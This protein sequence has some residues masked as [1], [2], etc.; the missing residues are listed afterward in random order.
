MSELLAYRPPTIN[1]ELLPSE[2]QLIAWRLTNALASLAGYQQDLEA[3]LALFDFCNH[4]MTG[5]ET[6]EPSIGLFRSWRSLAGRDGAMSIYH[7]GMT[8]ERVR[9]VIFRDCPCLASHFDRS[10][11]RSVIGSFDQA[12]PNWKSLRNAVAHVAENFVDPDEPTK[13]FVPSG[14]DSRVKIARRNVLDG[15]KFMHTIAGK[16][17]SYEL[18][19]EIV[20]KL[21]NIRGRYYRIFSKVSP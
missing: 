10:E 18:S 8:L 16:E 4:Q 5:L 21:H 12:F 19:A 7:F 17:C 1:M 11:L 20:Q 3:D 2:E 6:N 9:N 14:R 13:H 15:R